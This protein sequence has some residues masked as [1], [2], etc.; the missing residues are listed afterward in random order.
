MMPVFGAEQDQLVF[1]RRFLDAKLG[2]GDPAVH[3]LLNEHAR[4]LLAMAPQKDT[5]VDAVSRAIARHLSLRSTSPEAIARTVGT[6]TRTLR[7]RLSALGKSYQDLLNEIRHERARHELA[8][9][10]HTID[11][12]AENACYS[13]RGAF[14]RAFQ[15]YA[16]QSP[17]KYREQSRRPDGHRATDANRPE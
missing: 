5:F 16:G 4:N 9:T 11:T 3:D 7:R 10:D 14:E 15:R 6:S 17:S 8:H 1:A 12:I 13:S 2:G